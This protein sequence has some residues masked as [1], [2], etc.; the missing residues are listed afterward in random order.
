MK[1]HNSS[2]CNDNTGGDQVW[3][4]VPG[5]DVGIM[6]D[7]AGVR[8]S[9]PSGNGYQSVAVETHFDNPNNVEN[10]VD[11]SG[12]R[13]YYTA[14]LRTYDIGS[15]QLGDPYVA[16]RNVVIPPGW[17]DFEFTCPNSGCFN[18][19]NGGQDVTVFG[20]VHHMHG[21]GRSMRTRL[22]DASDNLYKEMVTE[23]YDFNFQDYLRIEPFT[24][25]TDTHASVECIYESN[26]EDFGL[27]SEQEMCMTFLTYYP[28][29][30]TDPRYC[31]YHQDE[32]GFGP[33]P[34]CTTNQY[35]TGG[36]SSVAPELDWQTFTDSPGV[37]NSYTT[38]TEEP[39]TTTSSPTTEASTDVT[40]RVLLSSP[41]RVP[42][43][44]PLRVPPSPLRV[45]LTSPLRVL[46][47]SPPR[48]PLTSPLTVPLTS[49]LMLLLTSP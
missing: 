26:G 7:V 2:D 45:P 32:Y 46:P 11:N 30:T 31:G 6:P 33:F 42:L 25:R 15:L 43:T 38:T 39:T 27:G 35:A 29:A 17:N 10:E 13:F 28:S 41:P 18:T 49:P 34:G 22:Y 23:F 4:W 16:A 44:S 14:N 37:C 20:V 8:I 19:L 24:F 3:A 21:A 47:S 48:V 12:V 40:M 9:G 36:N 5:I 1:V